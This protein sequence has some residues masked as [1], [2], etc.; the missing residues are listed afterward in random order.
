MLLVTLVML[1]DTYI[2][3]ESDGGLLLHPCVSST[4]TLDPVS[5]REAEPTLCEGIA[6]TL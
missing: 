6:P 1:Q 3:L 5:V 2:E 4:H